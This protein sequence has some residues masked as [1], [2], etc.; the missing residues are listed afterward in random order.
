MFDIRRYTAD[1]ANEWNQF[2]AESKNGTFLFDRR[3]MDYHSDRFED[4]SLLFYVGERLLA[5][6][7]AHLSGDMLCSHQGLTYGGLLMS[8]HLTVVQTMTLFRELNESLRVEGIRR[9]IYKAIPWIYHRLSA[10]EDLYALF[11]ECRAR[12][13]ARDFSTNIFLQVGLR[14]E[15]VRRRGVARAQKV[16]VCVERSDNYA[17]FWPVLTENLIAKHSVKPVHTLQEIELL[18]GRFPENIQLYQA[19]LE[20]EVLGGVVLYVSP[21][22]VH[23]QYSSA[24]PEGKKL[25]VIDL[26]YDQIF[27]D[28]HDYP[29][30]D[31]G[32]S[33]E[34]PDGSGLNENLVFQKEG[35]GGRG[36]CYDIYEYEL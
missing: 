28:Y 5:V 16:G 36:L 19:R 10:D 18:H 29:Y 30:F 14:W 6:L 25:G 11:H 15:R 27:K 9:V 2:V 17:S 23:A 7:P 22:V 20:G 21:Q 4:H 35:Y 24:T 34:H 26:L 1:T 32:R 31:F 13:I 33:T 3:Y 8:P 12:M